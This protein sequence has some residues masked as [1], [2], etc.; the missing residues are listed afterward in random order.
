[1]WISHKRLT[2]DEIFCLCHMLEK[3][4]EYNGTIQQLLKDSEKALS[5]IQ[6]RSIVHFSH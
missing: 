5:L 4:W 3:K 1:V 6:K 2:T